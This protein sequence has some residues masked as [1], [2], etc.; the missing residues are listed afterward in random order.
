VTTPE[1]TILVVEDDDA[2]RRLIELALVFDGFRVASAT[3][4]AEALGCLNR[5]T[6]ALVVLDLVLPWVN[7]LEVLATMRETVRLQ[8]V[9]VLVVTGTPV[10]DR[11]IGDRGPHKILRKPFNVEALAPAVQELLARASLH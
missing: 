2:M 4:G 8:M 1:A 7:G 10:T 9:P 6:P 3:N 5:T 11:D